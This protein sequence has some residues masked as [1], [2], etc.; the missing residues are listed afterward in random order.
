MRL[1]ET[2]SVC[3]VEITEA[4]TK[5]NIYLTIH[6]YCFVDKIVGIFI[7][8]EILF[9]ILRAKLRFQYQVQETSKNKIVL[10]VKT[11]R[12]NTKQQFKKV[13]IFVVVTMNFI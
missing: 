13:N 6:Y 7:F 8:L 9:L 10:I 11:K 5:L 1:V 12:V 2:V 4:L 3:Y